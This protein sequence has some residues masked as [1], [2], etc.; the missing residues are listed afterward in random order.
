MT[1][2]PRLAAVVAVVAT[3]FLFFPV[4]AVVLALLAVVIAAVID[5][6]AVRHPPAAERAVP[7][8]VAR[9]LPAALAV[10]VDGAPGAVEIRQAVPPDLSLEPGVAVGRLDA[11]LIPRRRGRHTLPPAAVRLTGPLGLGRW[12]HQVGAD[13][14]LRVYP[15]VVAA[16]R[17]AVAVRRGDFS[18]TGRTRGPLG[19]GTDFESVRDYSPDDD[20]RQVNWRATA[21]LGRPM[22]NQYRTDRDRDVVC[23]IDTGRLMAAPL[24]DRTRLDAAVDAAVAVAFVADEVGDRSGVVAF[25]HEIRRRL[26]PRRGGGRRV[27]HALFDVEPR[28]IESDYELAF[29][30]VAGTKRA[31]VM[32]FTD[33]FDEAAAHPLLAA[34][35]I[36][37]RRHAVVVASATDPDLRAIIERLPAALVDVYAAAATL[38]LL[39]A[40]ERSA[41]QLRRCGAVVLEA[42]PDRLG[43]ACVGAYLRMKARA[44][45]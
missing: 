43:A 34:M 44:R 32:V 3:G 33:L 16:R 20:I 26:G 22:S 15:D 4:L 31:M 35:P 14:D 24:G 30:A 17:I 45:L 8:L 27:V 25:D 21:R 39:D 42:S 10:R 9:G 5:A 6:S 7:P 19:I 41:H 37:V 36:L 12:D 2:A 11:V 13:L 23:L 1:P 29:Q 18:E 40:R 38:D 28:P